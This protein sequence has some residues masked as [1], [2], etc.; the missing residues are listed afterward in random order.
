MNELKKQVESLMS[1]VYRTLLDYD[2]VIL[3]NEQYDNDNDLVW[4][5]PRVGVV[6]KYGYYI[7]FAITKI[8]KGGEITGKGLGEDWGDTYS[9]TVNELSYGEAVN[10]LGFLCN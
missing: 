3:T 2:E 1:D 5:V 8:T 9:F 6:T 7:E 4:D 10:L